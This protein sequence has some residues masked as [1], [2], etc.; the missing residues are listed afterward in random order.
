MASF[1]QNYYPENSVASM[2][3]NDMR[4][5]RDYILE[6][7]EPLLDTAIIADLYY[8][9]PR[10]GDYEGFRFSLNYRLSREKDFEFV[11]VE[12]ARLWSTK[13]LAAIGTKRVKASDMAQMTSY[14]VDELERQRTDGTAEGG[15]YQH[16]LTFFEWEYGVLP[17]DA[18]LAALLP[19]PMLPDQRSVVLRFESPQHYTNH[20]VEVRYPTNNRGGWLQGLEDFFHEHLVPGALMTISR[21]AEPNVFA[22]SYEEDAERTE[23]L[24]TLD[25]KKNKFAFV[26]VT[27]YCTVNS[28]RLLTQ[29]KYGR[30]R[31]LKSLPMNERRKA[32]SVLEHVFEA[33]GEQLGTRSEPRYMSTL[34]ELLIGY[35]VLRPGSQTL[36]SQLLRD[37]D[38]YE[39]DEAT[40]GVYYFTP[41]PKADADSDDDDEGEDEELSARGRYSRYED[42]E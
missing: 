18:S 16:L 10:Q 33:I 2:G 30:L 19:R 14:L 12:G 37:G 15:A 25:E 39:A 9:N 27:F 38:D 34:D 32:E 20:L 17:L 28:D 41:E 26:N 7:G 23:R 29:Q 5:I 3:K 22:I 11:G 1:G 8:H 36:L 6:V 13:G 42:D 31:N 35:T 21:T 24:L 40:P 4:R